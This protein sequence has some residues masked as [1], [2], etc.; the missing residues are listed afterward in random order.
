MADVDHIR[1]DTLRLVAAYVRA[2]VEQRLAE[3]G[4]GHGC[5][6]AAARAFEA[7][8]L[9]VIEQNMWAAVGLPGLTVELE[10]ELEPMGDG[11]CEWRRLDW[12]SP[13]HGPRCTLD[14]DHDGDHVWEYEERRTGLLGG[15]TP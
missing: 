8:R 15:S 9:A 2:Q 13:P 6:A 1:R 11:R 10:V 14:R 7:G 3:L 5:E 12:A 4:D